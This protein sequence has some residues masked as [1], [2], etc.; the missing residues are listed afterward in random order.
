MVTAGT[1]AVDIRETEASCTSSWSCP[2]SSTEDVEITAENGVLTIHGTKHSE[3]KE[4]EQT[5]YHVVERTYGAFMRTFRSQGIDDEQIGAEFDARTVA[6]NS[7]AALPQ[8]RG[9]RSIP[10]ERHSKPRSETENKNDVSAPR[11]QQT[12]RG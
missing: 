9:S 3:R 7:K 11:S 1:P 10:V 6:S 12:G 8:P 5:R 2:D 4:D